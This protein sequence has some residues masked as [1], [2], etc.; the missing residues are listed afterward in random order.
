MKKILDIDSFE[1]LKDGRLFATGTNPEFNTYSIS[2]AASH[3]TGEKFLSDN[4]NYLQK[5][6]VIY[7]SVIQQMWS[8]QIYQI[9]FTSLKLDEIPSNVSLYEKTKD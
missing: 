2:E 6:Q 9:E 5:V 1:K 4:K 7:C 3:F 8:D